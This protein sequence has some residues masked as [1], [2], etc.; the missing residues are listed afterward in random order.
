[1]PVDKRESCV[2]I[3][4]PGNDRF[5]SHLGPLGRLWGQAHYRRDRPN[6]LRMGREGDSSHRC[7]PAHECPMCITPYRQD[8]RKLLKMEREGDSSHQCRPAHEHPLSLAP[9]EHYPLANFDR[10]HCS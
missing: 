4:F 8:R 2:G 5:V 3:S 1:M 10:R 6:L 7:R 9:R